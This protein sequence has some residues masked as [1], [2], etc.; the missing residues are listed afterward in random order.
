MA[1]LVLD[2]VGMELLLKKTL[3][4]GAL[5]AAF[6]FTGTGI[7]MSAEVSGADFTH[8]SLFE[9]RVLDQMLGRNFT[10]EWEIPAAANRFHPGLPASLH[11]IAWGAPIQLGRAQK[12]C[13]IIQPFEL[14]VGFHEPAKEEAPAKMLAIHSVVV[15]PEKWRQLWGSVK[16]QDIAKL[17]AIAATGDVDA[18]RKAAQDE[19]AVL[20][21]LSGGIKIVPVVEPTIRTVLCELPSDVFHRVFL[22]ISQPKPQKKL[23]LWNQAFPEFIPAPAVPVAPEKKASKN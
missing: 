6:T 7:A 4:S 5:A 17:Q 2:S 3:I 18:G 21:K 16:P 23:K 12:M 20:T 14:V 15:E 1:I 19:A 22:D 11:F 13:E 10:E 9:R 8:T